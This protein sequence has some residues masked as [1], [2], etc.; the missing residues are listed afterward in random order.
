MP[1]SINGIGTHYWFKSHVVERRGAC[2]FCGRV[3]TIRSYDTILWFVVAFV[4]VIPLGRKRVIDECRACT[5][6]RVIPLKQ[7]TEMR[8]ADLDRAAEAAGADP[9]SDDLAAAAVATAVAYQ[10][11]GDFDVLAETFGEGDGRG[12]ATQAVLGAGHALFGRPG[13]AEAAYRRSLALADDPA[14]RE[15]LARLLLTPGTPKKARPDDARPL[16]AHLFDPTPTPAGASAPR[17][18]SGGG[19]LF[20]LAEAYQAQGR[21]DDVLD[22]LDALAAN[23]PAVAGAKDVKKLRKRAGKKATRAR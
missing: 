21:P 6:H 4:P 16:L 1:S 5:R 23:Y 11:E 12:P 3:G 2:S 15:D 18:P 19:L 17:D 14:V 7:F 10:S 13:E 22:A 20:L 8:R 9:E